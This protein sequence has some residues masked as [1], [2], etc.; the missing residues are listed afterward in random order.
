[1]AKPQQWRGGGIGMDNATDAQMHVHFYLEYLRNVSRRLCR[2]A[3][4]AAQKGRTKIAG[5]DS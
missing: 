5:P 2:G 4:N 1:V 3:Q